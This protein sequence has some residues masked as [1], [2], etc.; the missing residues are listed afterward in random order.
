MEVE[1]LSSPPGIIAGQP[2]GHVRRPACPEDPPICDGR[3][4]ARGTD[5]GG[6]NV[7]LP[8]VTGSRLPLANGHPQSESPFTSAQIPVQ[9]REPSVHGWL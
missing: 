6:P 2:P 4:V 1:N 8:E 5:Y 7:P 9:H 3:R